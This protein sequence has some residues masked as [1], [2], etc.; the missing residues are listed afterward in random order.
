MPLFYQ[1]TINN[2]AKIGV[3]HIEESESFFTEKVP[4]PVQHISHPHKKLQH[5][6]GRYLLQEL[7]PG[8]PYHLIE[9]ADTRKPFLPNEA[10][11]FSISHC[12]DYAAV[13]VSEDNRV[14][15]DIEIPDKKIDRIQHKFLN[16]EEL[17]AVQKLILKRQNLKV[18]KDSTSTHYL[19]LTTHNFHLLTLL[20]SCKEAVFKWFGDGGVDFRKHIHLQFDN[21]HNDHGEIACVFTKTN[22]EQLRL[23][24]Q[25]LNTLWLTWVI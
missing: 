15:V 11:H 7:F 21:L 4:L 8:F 2:S 18:Y 10:Y 22:N 9:I 19:S 1:H 3:W 25:K 24:Y 12:G 14:G 13:F 16:D 20:W 23:S 17:E 5:L 6:A